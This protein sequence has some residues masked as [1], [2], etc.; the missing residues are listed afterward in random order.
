MLQIIL[1]I[2]LYSR[3]N[4]VKIRLIFEKK[5]NLKI[6]F[7]IFLFLKKKSQLKVG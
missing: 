7:P 1:A 6:I 4:S 2:F 3:K 5:K